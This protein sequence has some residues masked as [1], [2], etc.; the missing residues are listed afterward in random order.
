MVI[1]GEVEETVSSRDTRGPV[2]RE[3]R[4]EMGY[5]RK[6]HREIGARQKFLP[7]SEVSVLRGICRGECNLPRHTGT[8]GDVAQMQRRA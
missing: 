7:L 1:A 5:G 3:S 2:R 6:Q 8:C 4:D